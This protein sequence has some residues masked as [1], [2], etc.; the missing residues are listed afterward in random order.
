MVNR[1]LYRVLMPDGALSHDAF[2]V[3]EAQPTGLRS[4]CVIAVNDRDATQVIVHH[5]RLVRVVFGATKTACQ[6]CGHVLGVTEDDVKCPYTE[7]G[8]CE[9]EETP[10]TLASTQ[11][12]AEHAG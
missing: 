6:R 4:G 11:P 8:S 1:E 3:P 10:E 7:G 5:A 12:C 2:F 9:L